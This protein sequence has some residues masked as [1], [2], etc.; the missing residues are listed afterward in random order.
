MSSATPD[1]L[2]TARS[3][4]DRAHSNHNGA[5]GGAERGASLRTLVTAPV[6]ALQFLTIVPP[7]VRRTPRA[8]DLGASDAFFP[9]VGLLLGFGLAGTDLALAGVLAPMVRDVLLVVFLAAA[10]G[11]L[12][13]DGFVDTFDGLFA[14]GGPARRLEIMRDPRAGTF[15]VVAVVMLLLLEVA[16]LGA[17]VPEYRTAALILAPCLGRWAIVMAT[18]LFPYARKEGLGRGFKDGIRAPYA[19][20]AGATA[21]IAAGWLGGGFGLGVFAGV[22]IG[23]LAIGNLVSARLGGLTG[24]TYGALCELTEAGVWLAFGLRFGLAAT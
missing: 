16:A 10:T 1:A 17:L 12:H 8:A 4:E 5:D 11:A 15:G 7:L 9:A 20:V 24:D 14:P 19:L 2:P 21:L 3:L 23:V 22:S 13:L 18:W 6:F